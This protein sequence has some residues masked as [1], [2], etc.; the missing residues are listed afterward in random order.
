MGININL[1]PQRRKI[2]S[3]A[4]LVYLSLVMVWL[5]AASYFGASYY[6]T[7]KEIA[8]LNQEVQQQEK[9]LSNAEQRVTQGDGSN[10]LQSYLD[11]SN[12]LQHL[13]YPTTVM[14]DE[15]ARTLPKNGK[16]S[17]VT[18]NSDGKISLQGRF[19]Q[20]DDVAAY[21]H[22]LQKSEHIV[23]ASIKSIT[24]AP[25]EWK[26]PVDAEGKPMSPSLQIVGG[27]VMPRYEA[28]FEILAV[29]IDAKGI[30]SMQ[31]AEPKQANS[32][33]VKS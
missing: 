21:L 7:K 1:L 12:K 32:P 14:L 25:V 15:L 4:L 31:K 27:D 20:Y 2:I 6:F 28:V 22:N 24:A 30:E 13:F 33:A 3:R 23:K 16:L 18:Y 11:L 5:A 17:Q 26:G 19:E 9:V 29:T 10:S 8:L